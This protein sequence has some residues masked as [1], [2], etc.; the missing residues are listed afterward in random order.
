MDAAVSGYFSCSDPVVVNNKS[1]SVY[2]SVIALQLLIL[3]SLDMMMVPS[4]VSVVK[5][6]SV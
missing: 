3:I 2:F 6:I 5:F 4:L 1:K